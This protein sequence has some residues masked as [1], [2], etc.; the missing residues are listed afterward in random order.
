MQRKWKFTPFSLFVSSIAALGGLLFG[1]NTSIIS[2]ALLFLKRDFGLSTIEQEVI[3]SVLLIGAL[4]GAFLGGFIADQFGRK[5]TLFLTVILFLIGTVCL[6]E[7]AGFDT[8]LIGRSILGLA[9]G[10]TSMAVPLY[11][12]EM[13]PP[14]SRGALVSLNQLLITIGILIAYTV[15][16]YYADRSDWRSMFLFGILPAI[17]QGIGLFFIPE[18]PSWLIGRGRQAAAEKVLHRIRVAESNKKLVIENKE[19]D[20]P[21]RKNWRELL[22]PSVR[23]SFFVGIGISVFQQITGIN[24]VIYYAPQIFQLA[25]YSTAQ[26]AIQATMIIGSVNVFMTVVALWLIDRIGRRPLMIGGLIGMTAA[27][28][29]LGFSF[30][31]SSEA[32]GAAALGGLIVYVAFFAVSLGPCAWLIIS[33]IYPAR[34]PRPGHGDSN[35]RKLGLQLHRLSHL[36]LLAP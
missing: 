8:L 32:I 35:L 14:Q 13:S 28:A 12:A 26:Q 6:S 27:L 25:G 4:V 24:T 20:S 29:V 5:K 19:E 23:K 16:F 17:A 33:E 31:G 7:A 9:I 11:I 30:F 36:P 2:G 18:T 15:S 1:F 10:I 3:V 22:K 34:H 21:S